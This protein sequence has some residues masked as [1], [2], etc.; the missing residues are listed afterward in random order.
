GGLGSVRDVT[1]TAPGGMSLEGDGNRFPPP[2]LFGGRPGTV[3]EVSLNPD[4]SDGRE[5]PSKFPYMKLHANDT[6]RTVSPSGGGYGDPFERDPARVLEDLRDGFIGAQAARS[7]YGV[8]VR[9]AEAGVDGWVL[10][11][12]ETARLRSRRPS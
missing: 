8:G 7:D 6:I 12:A 5:M 2:G 9:E 4:R 3:G 1:F 10:D 11:E